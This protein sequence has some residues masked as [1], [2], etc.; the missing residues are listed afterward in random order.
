MVNRH[1]PVARMI[2][3]ISLLLLSLLCIITP[4]NVQA[5]TSYFGNIGSGTNDGG[6]VDILIATQYTLTEDGTVTQIGGYASGSGHWK[7]GIYADND[8]SPGALLAANNSA[9]AV[10]TGDNTFNIGPVYLTAGTYWLAIL[11]ETANRRYQAGTPNQAAYIQN[12]GFSNN[13][14]ANFGSSIETQNND[15]VAYARYSTTI[16]TELT[17][18]CTPPSV[19]SSGSMETTISG[20]LS[21]ASN[22]DT[23]IAG[24][25]IA[26]S[27]FNGENWI[28]ITT[29]VTDENGGLLR[30][31]GSL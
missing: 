22:P 21:L 1:K 15:Y 6:L 26:L 2:A 9:N 18:L 31:L 24:K 5:A 25:N 7:L 11:T 3:T 23:G 12:Y 8:G 14:P 20:K 29:A 13:L 4:S 27:Y 28:A 16:A 30:E 17:A 10:S 19:P